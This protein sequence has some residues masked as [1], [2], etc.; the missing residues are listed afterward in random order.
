MAYSLID[1]S[2]STDGQPISITATSTPGT[3][4]HTAGASGTDWVTLYAANEHTAD[5]EITV[6]WGA[7]QNH[8][9]ISIPF[10][11]GDYLIADRLPISNSGVIKVF[12]GTT[13]VIWIHGRVVRNT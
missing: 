10:D 1:L 7:A 5:V 6:E 9:V 3:T 2:A 11:E 4:V 13:A 8:K 12:A